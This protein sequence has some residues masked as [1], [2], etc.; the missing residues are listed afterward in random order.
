MNLRDAAKFMFGH[1]VHSLMVKV[2]EKYVGIITESDLYRSIIG[3]GL[4]PKTTLVSSTMSFPV[5]T[6]ESG[7]EL[8]Q[9]KVL[10]KKH[11]ARHLAVTREGKIVGMLSLQDLLN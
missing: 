5:I 8:D 6:I 2:A 10:M 3:S 11:H 7:Y 9:A 1:G 4:D